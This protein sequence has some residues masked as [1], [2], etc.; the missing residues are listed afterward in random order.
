MIKVEEHDARKN[1]ARIMGQGT[2]IAKRFYR[3]INPKER[4]ENIASQNK[5]FKFKCHRCG[6]IG[7]KAS[8]C[9][10]SS[11]DKT[12]EKN[13]E[14]GKMADVSDVSVFA[15]VPTKQEAFQT[16]ETTYVKRWCLDSGCTSHLCGD[17][18]KFM[19]LGKIATEKLNLANNSSTN[20]IGRGTIRLNAEVEGRLKN[21]D[22]EDALLVPDLRTNLL[23][24]SKITDRGFKVIFDEKSARVIDRQ[25]ATELEASR[26]DRLYY[27]QENKRE[28]QS[29]AVVD[30]KSSRAPVEDWHRRMGHLN[31]KD[32]ST[33]YH[34]RTVLGMDIVDSER[35]FKCE[36]CARGKM[37]RSSF[38]KKS[39]RQTDLLELIHSDVCGPMKNESLG[40][41]KYFVTFIDDCSRWCFVKMIRGKNEVLNAFKQ[42]KALVENQIG[43]KIKC[44]QSDNGKEYINREFD[45]FLNKNGIQRR[46]TVTHTPEQNGVAE[47]KNRTLV[48]MAKC[49]LIQSELSPSF[50]EEAI[51][52][53]NYIRNRCPT[54]SLGGKTPFERWTGKPPDVGYFQEFGCRVYSL[55]REPNKEKFGSRSRKG[56]FVGYAENSKAFRIWIPD[57]HRIDISRDVEFFSASN[58]SVQ[59]H[60]GPKDESIL[61]DRREIDFPM[62][63]DDDKGLIDE[64]DDSFIDVRGIDSNTEPLVNTRRGRGRPRRERT[65]LRGRPRKIY[66]VANDKLRTIKDAEFAYLAEVPVNQSLNEPDAEEW[67][68]AMTEEMK[69]IIKNDTW[70][71]V[72]RPVGCE[73]VGS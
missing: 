5:P 54:S 25:G 38:P 3:R 73:V 12:S 65:G 57:E 36:V 61:E 60:N 47:R 67:V 64:S 6:K 20:I 32:L 1:D 53:A 49:L 58:V 71:L 13:P 28:C 59:V 39:N 7:H 21:V 37:T 15:C 48:E 70:I 30:G 27:M 55:I 17:S 41:S 43:R 40:R 29:A 14:K 51:N 52:T 69:S 72:N 46:L 50:W 44:L 18:S 11:E 68:Q 22:L 56:I 23:S 16:K 19:D 2:M 4:K 24:V 33:S 9:R 8:D 42:F 34:N 63:Y 10:S 66:Q 35:D 26:I 62:R 31:L 45:D